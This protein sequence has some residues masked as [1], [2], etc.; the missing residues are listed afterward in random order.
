MS[1]QGLLTD[2]REHFIYR[3]DCEKSILML[4]FKNV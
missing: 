4:D 1:G 3:F 2:F